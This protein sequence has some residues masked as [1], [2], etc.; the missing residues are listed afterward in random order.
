MVRRRLAVVLLSGTLVLILCVVAFAPAFA[1]IDARRIE[2][3]ERPLFCWSYWIEGHLQYAD[4]GSALYRG[5]GY[6]I[7]R[8]QELLVSGPGYETGMKVSFSLPWH[9]RY[10]WE[11]T[12]ESAD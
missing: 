4:G 6:D 12:G 2:R 11:S 10:S 9:K 8:K 5:L 7:K 3:Y 1:A